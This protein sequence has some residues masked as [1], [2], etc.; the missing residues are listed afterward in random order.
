MVQDPDRRNEILA[1]VGTGMI[2]FAANAS[3]AWW[4]LERLHRGKSQLLGVPVLALGLVF[5]EAFALRNT[6]ERVASAF[7]CAGLLACLVVTG[8][9][10]LGELQGGQ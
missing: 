4:F 6:S 10:W 2:L 5:A 9:L 3:G 1:G 7:L 8:L